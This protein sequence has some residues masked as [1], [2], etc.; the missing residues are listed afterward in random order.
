[1]SRIERPRAYIC[2]AKR[3]SSSVLPP[4]AA[5]ISECQP[6]MPRTCGICHRDAP[7]W[8]IDSNALTPSNRRMHPLQV[9]ATIRLRLAG[10]SAP[11]GAGEP[12][13]GESALCVWSLRIGK[14][15]RLPSFRIHSC[16]QPHA[17]RYR[18]RPAMDKSAP[19]LFNHEP[20]IIHPKLHNL[21]DTTA[22]LSWAA[23]AM[24]LCGGS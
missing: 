4:S 5:R 3:S 8:L 17:D 2:T 11:P 22:F 12:E 1:M 18:T 9:T 10:P 21:A 7:L 14:S 13:R 15:C 24:A 23:S 19:S 20:E 6:T 16:R